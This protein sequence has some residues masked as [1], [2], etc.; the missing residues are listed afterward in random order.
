MHHLILGGARSGKSRYAEQLAHASQL[1]ISVIV[2][3][4]AH[5]AEM[6][7]RIA[8]HQASRPTHWQVIESPFNL[9]H[10]LQ[11]HAQEGHCLI[12]DCLTLWLTN[13]L[14]QTPE[15]LS[16]EK[17]A[18]IAVLPTLPGTVLLV[19]NELGSGIVP[20]GELTRQ[21]IDEAGWLNQAVAG[22]CE[23]VTLVVAGLPLI[24]KYSS[25]SGTD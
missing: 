4:Q 5:D 8:H 17:N 22:V 24:L 21:F 13:L 9:A 7:Q 18:L 20:L 2:T 11:T 1:S 15:C 12:V 19:S 16:H 6:A 25:W 10:T 3:A 23:R 14:C